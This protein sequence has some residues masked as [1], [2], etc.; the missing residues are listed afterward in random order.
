MKEPMGVMESA[1]VSLLR[2]VLCCPL[3]I[4]ITVDFGAKGLRLGHLFPDCPLAVKGGRSEALVLCG[5][6]T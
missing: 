3:L 6:S 1:C 2:S 4:T 5:V